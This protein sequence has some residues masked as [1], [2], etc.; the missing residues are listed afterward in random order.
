MRPFLGVKGDILRPKSKS[1]P[2]TGMSNNDPGPAGPSSRPEKYRI[3]YTVTRNGERIPLLVDAVGCPV[4]TATV[5]VFSELRA[6]GRAVNTI[7]ATLRSI[8][9]FSLFLDIYEIDL[10]E[11]LRAGQLLTLREIDALV[12]ICRLPVDQVR[13]FTKPIA[14]SNVRLLPR[15]RSQRSSPTAVRSAFCATRLRSIRDYVEWL[16]VSGFGTGSHYSASMAATVQA[17]TKALNSRMPVS[18][19]RLRSEREGLDRSEVD[20][21]LRIVD[22]AAR[23]NPWTDK[24]T[25]VRNE[26][27]IWLLVY[28]GVRRGELL[29]VRVS[30]LNFR[31]ETATIHRRAD[32]QDDP[33]LYQPNAKTQARELPMSSALAQ[34]TR[35][36]VISFR[37]GVEGARKHDFLFVATDTGRPLSINGFA[38]I[39]YALKEHPL[40][41][42]KLF[43]HLLRHTW[44]DRL[45]EQLDENAT[46]EEAERKLRSYLMGWS[47]TSGTA[48]TYTRRHV[49]RKAAEA[50]VAMQNS[51]F[52]GRTQ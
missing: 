37:N 17:F 7:D 16:A 13:A 47:E 45:S 51:L 43:A 4:L 44:N 12:Q 1:F 40:L 19:S 21:L 11:R 3:K 49:R 5:Y 46:P 50:S 32:D 28:L 6:R 33:R 25:R 36:Y 41:P 20:E 27:I 30:D 10:Q 26:L 9:L 52:K 14:S 48:S 39:F 15:A 23:D 22:P 42:Q 2:V 18:H 8:L 31:N 38:K 34:R 35:E 24:H 29:G